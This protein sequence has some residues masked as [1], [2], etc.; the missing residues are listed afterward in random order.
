MRKLPLAVNLVIDLSCIPPVLLPIFKIAYEV[1]CKH[2][3][4]A[5]ELDIGIYKFIAGETE[6]IPERRIEV[7]KFF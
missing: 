2:C 4:V 5:I 6:S 3:R 7:A 1:E